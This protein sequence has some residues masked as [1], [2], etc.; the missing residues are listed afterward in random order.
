MGRIPKLTSLLLSLALIV[1]CAQIP[2]RADAPFH[3]PLL[4]L[5]SSLAVDHPDSESLTSA[6][7]ENGYGIPFSYDDQ[8][9]IITTV[10][11]TPTA[12]GSVISKLSSIGEITNDDPTFNAV[13]FTTNPANLDKAQAITG[14]TEFTPIF[15]IPPSKNFENLSQTQATPDTSSTTDYCQSLGDKDSPL[16]YMDLRK[17]TGLDGSGVKIGI[18]S[19]SFSSTTNWN[20]QQE[21]LAGRLP[22]PGNPCGYTTPVRELGTPSTDATDEGRAMAEY[23][24]EIA[25]GAELIFSGMGDA[26]DLGLANAVLNLINAGVDI[27]VDDLAVADNPVFQE[28]YTAMAYRLANLRG[29]M[30]FSSIGNGEETVEKGGTTYPVNG[31][32]ADAYQPGTCPSWVTD[33]LDCHQFGDGYTYL[34]YT[35]KGNATSEKLYSRFETAN[36]PGHAQDRFELRIYDHTTHRL[37]SKFSD[38]QLYGSRYGLTTIEDFNGSGY[39]DVVFVRLRGTDTPP[40]NFI[41]SWGNNAVSIEDADYYIPGPGEDLGMSSTTYVDSDGDNVTPVAAI[42]QLQV[43]NNEV[44]TDTPPASYSSRSR[45]VFYRSPISSY[46]TGAGQQYYYTPIRRNDP[47]PLAGIAGIKTVWPK[48]QKT[49]FQGRFYGTSAAAPSLAGLAALLR[50]QYPH[51]N[52]RIFQSL[53]NEVLVLPIVREDKNNPYLYG[54]RFATAQQLYKA[55]SYTNLR[56]LHPTCSL[57]V[58]NTNLN[59][60]CDY[61]PERTVYYEYNGQRDIN[62]DMTIENP[63]GNSV[64]LTFMHRNGRTEALNYSFTL[65]QATAPNPTLAFSIEKNIITIPDGYQVALDENFENLLSTGQNIQD[66]L[67]HQIW[68]RQVDANGNAISETVSYSI[69][70]PEPEK[71]NPLGIILAVLAIFGVIGAIIAGIATAV[72]QGLIPIPPV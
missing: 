19:D 8:G 59:I 14:I 1:T 7:S 53:Y 44:T 52:N 3:N 62:G 40:F 37:V 16:K 61:D 36:H 33:A 13:T 58:E 60:H 34:Q 67:G 20:M 28:G 11:F 68:I 27:I 47:T 9:R 50:Q 39:A 65:G 45:R 15:K 21:I 38:S 64:I 55:I 63:Q 32:T 57:L 2:V 23:I 54:Y 71:S 4:S 42:N 6:L 22:G 5:I 41:L 70:T 29:I 69:P 30:G 56:S 12:R 51:I 26:G 66:L 46:D 43:K 35:V 25:P 18:I 10:A 72:Q 17:E 49:A 31:Y 48:V 24:H